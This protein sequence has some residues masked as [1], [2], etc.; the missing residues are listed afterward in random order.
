[1]KNGTEITIG[2]VALGHSEKVFI[3]ETRTEPR[4]Q[5]KLVALK[6]RS[7]E[8]E[9]M[10]IEPIEE[11]ALGQLSVRGVTPAIAATA[12]ASVPR[13][14]EPEGLE[15]NFHP[16]QS[17]G[18]VRTRENKLVLAHLGEDEITLPPDTELVG[19]APSPAGTFHV[20][21]YDDA[22]LEKFKLGYRVNGTPSPNWVALALARREKTLAER[23]RVQ[24]EK[25][26]KRRQAADRA[27]QEARAAQKR[28]AAEAM[29][30]EMF[31]T[32]DSEVA[33]RLREAYRPALVQGKKVGGKY[34]IEDPEDLGTEI[35]VAVQSERQT[36]R[37]QNI[38]PDT[39]FVKRR[40][41]AAEALAAR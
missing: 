29:P 6:L 23:R 37:E 22:T 24:H 15:I 4:C 11:V 35:T 28:R 2:Y 33:S 5:A 10:F 21:A 31:E 14:E 12:D 40:E 34:F 1:M 9:G 38:D 13:L 41:E 16:V 39:V 32:A 17:L 36:L 30:I 25:D 7:V 20:S 8:T 18:I 27:A 3:G 19:V 26:E